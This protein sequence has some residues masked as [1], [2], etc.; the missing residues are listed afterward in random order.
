MLLGAC[1]ALTLACFAAAPSAAATPS[2]WWRL[3]STAEPSNIPP[4]GKST[5]VVT[6]VNVGDAE[7]DGS[8]REVKLVDTLPPGLKASEIHGTAGVG[9]AGE[10]DRGALTCSAAAEA[11]AGVLECAF[12]SALFGL[13]L[14][15]FEPLEV[16]IAVEAEAGAPATVENAVA[17]SGGQ[18]SLEGVLGGEVPA[19]S[20]K[21]PVAVSGA[22]VAFGVEHYELDAEN[23]GGSL[24]TQAGSHPFQLTTTIDLNGLGQ[25]HVGENQLARSALVKD[26][27]FKLPAGLIGNPNVGEDCTDTEFGHLEHESSN[28]CPADTAIGAAVVTIDEPKFFHVLTKSVPVFKLVPARGEPA[29]FGFEVL[30]V[31]V[32]LDT[33]VRSGSDY[34]V[35]VTVSNIDETAAFMRSVVTFW[36]VPG[37]PSHDVSRGWA[38]LRDEAGCLVSPAE[39]YLPF[40]TMPRSCEGPLQTLV[41]GDG[42]NEP[43]GRPLLAFAPTEA[44]AG[45]TG[46]EKL[47]FGASISVAPDVQSTSTATGLNVGI[48]VPQEASLNPTGLA[49]GDLK[50]IAVMLPEGVAL[51]PAGG[52]GLE[53][54]SEEQ[55]GFESVEAHTGRD[56]FS[57]A[58]PSCP[59]ASKIADVK[60]KSPLLA[61][62]LEGSVYLATPAPL[63]EGGMNPFGSLVAQYLVAKD[64]VSGV[65][66]K[67]PGE[68]RL[69]PSGQIESTFKY[70]PELPFEEAELHFFGED[71]SPLATPASC[72]SYTT[73]ATF[74]AWSGEEPVNSS[75]D[76]EILTGPNG[77]PCPNPLPFAPS[78]DAG[79]IN[80]QAG[81]FSQLTTTI[82]R[83]D[84]NQSIKQVQLQMPGGLTGLLSGVKLCGEGE[85]NAGTCGPESQIGETT[86]SVG[87][88]NDPFTVTGG[89][90][91][92]T[93]PYEGAPFG[94]SIVNPAKAGPFDLE[95][96]TPCDCVVVR[97]KIEVNPHTAALTITTD[98][99][100]GPYPIPRILDGIPLQIRHVNVTIN[101]PGFTINPTNCSSMAVTGTISS[102]EGSSSGVSAP[103]QVTNCATLAFAPKFSVSTSGK[104]SKA[105]GASLTTK[106][107]YP[108][109]P[110]GT[111]ADIAKVKVDLP[112]H[113][114][115]RLTT[116]QKACTNA[117]FELNPA[118]CP[119]ASKIGYA[120]VHTPLL[121]VPLEGPA[122]FVSH[123][124]EAFPSLTM[125]LQGD[126]VTV[127]LVGTTFI[128]KGG[129]TS[130]TFKAVPDQ[131]FSTFELV[132]PEGKYSALAANGDLCKKKLAMPTAFVAQNGA[133]IH[134]STAIDVTGCSGALSVVSSSVKKRTLTLSVYAPAA[135]KVT[136]SGKG[137]S[138]GSKSYSGREAL[139]FTL[140]QK[141]AGRLKTKIKLTFTPSKGKKQ[142]KTVKVSFKR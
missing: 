83:E 68:V 109:A 9:G 105:D 124:G 89:R 39:H 71:R 18:A 106:L 101:R 131:P 16:R 8:S 102:S 43:A 73:N 48:H 70:N 49:D 129:I 37:E 107:S 130:T 127:D 45:L 79:T 93:G 74:T 13:N 113:L 110:Q 5:I 62:P 28:S 29:R 142:T 140:K 4:G 84:G 26:L 32:V 25:I 67:L 24:D 136:A 20:V 34:G 57:D 1:A 126:N 52:D 41:E 138:S 75:S 111:Q 85:A 40:L 137:V 90:V 80:N 108:N 94:L 87:I 116:L 91:Y 86:V 27:N 139:T 44:M 7:V 98:S 15:P 120:V 81:A 96:G 134:E 10:G 6:A 82:N 14:R 19:A 21:E 104:T 123:G 31:P 135:G 95:K 50:E 103:F 77:G 121:P 78:L 76:F 97:A 35:T 64:P 59:D 11:A 119:A 118:N 55:I 17:V 125:V 46:C 99:A 56:L 60:I 30:G 3:N 38:C 117:Q 88:G 122:I 112:K 69:S 36:G 54:C 128:S 53:A 72:G 58:E 141:K 51:N 115:S 42:W 65:L 132:L 114:P 2:A 133:E 61:N 22:P 33:S 63:G 100:S 66:V 92:I 47:P 23:E 12:K